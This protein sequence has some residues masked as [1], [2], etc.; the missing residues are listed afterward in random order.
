MLN[1]I[2][3]LVA[4]LRSTDSGKV[5]TPRFWALVLEAEGDNALLETKGEQVR[6][7]LETPVQAGEK[8]LLARGN[9]TGG[10][11]QCR[12]LQRLAPGEQGGQL[13]DTVSVLFYPEQNEQ[14]PYLLT[15]E[16]EQKGENFSHNRRKWRFVLH[17]ENLGT[18]ILV[19]G[20]TEG[21]LS[22]QLLVES[23]ATAARL[24]R[25]TQ[26][27]GSD[28]TSGVVL[29]GIRVMNSSERKRTLGTGVSLDQH[30]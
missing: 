8:L 30:G 29:H 16:E 12:I 14:F 17:T 3:S 11:L 4:L 23:D 9:V 19:V 22:A 27:F 6:V 2:G 5:L 18:V 25:L 20:E 15:V 21:P 24:G 13:T 1:G 26:L 10:R 7:K 28:N